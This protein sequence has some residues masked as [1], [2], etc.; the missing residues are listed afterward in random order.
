MFK[1]G[2]VKGIIFDCYKTLIDIETDEDSLETYDIVS[3]WLLY[4]GVQISPEKLKGEYKKKVSK[5]FESSEQDYPEVKV[6]DIFSEICQE[7]AIWDIDEEILGI[8]TARLFRAASIQNIGTYSE[9]LE[10]LEIFE[11]YP[12]CIV[13]NA[14]RVFSELELKYLG[15]HKYFDFVIFSSDFGYKK[16]DERLFK[17]AQKRLD[18]NPEEIL[19]IGDTTEND[20]EPPQKLG[21]R[22]VHIEE[23]WKLTT[24][25]K[26]LF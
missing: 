1:R 9:S 26:H 8:E 12:K 18:I 25:F 23:A 2:K 4:Y 20:V 7:N 6:E 17:I 5:A 13:S 22:G 24:A 3:K 10:L 14:Q 16:P 11:D 19:S 15:L 21:M